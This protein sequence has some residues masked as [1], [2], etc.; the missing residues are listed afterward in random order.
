MEFATPECI[1]DSIRE[2]LNRRT[3]GYTRLFDSTYYNA[4][5]NGRKKC[6]DWVPK[7][8]NLFTSHGVIPA[9]YELTGYICRSGNEVLMLT[10]SYAYFR[11]AAQYSGIDYVCSDL[12]D[13]GHNGYYEID[14]RILKE[15]RRIHYR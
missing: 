2:R 1:I 10:L 12:V 13:R 3:F 14:L 7:Q 15:K 6:Y 9:L 11:N 4:F 8:E 5:P